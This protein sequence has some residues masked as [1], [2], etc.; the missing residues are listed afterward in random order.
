MLAGGVDWLVIARHL[1]HRSLQ[2]IQGYAAVALKSRVEA[3][4]ALERSL[5]S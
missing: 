4:N 2:A 3:V 5:A 1:G